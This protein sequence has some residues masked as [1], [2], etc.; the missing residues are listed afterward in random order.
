MNFGLLAQYWPDLWDGFVTTLVLSAI[1]LAVAT[2]V[3]AALALMR[4]SRVPSLTL[5]AAAYVS[6]FR[7]IPA[8]LVLF[9]TFYALP[10]FG[11]RLSPFGAA[12][13]GLSIVGAAYLSEDIRGGLAA[14]DSGQ[15]RAA[16]ALGLSW[17]HT[18]R[19]II[20]PQAIPIIIPP[21]FT[22]AIIIVKSTSLAS[23]VA[24]SDLTGQAARAASITYDPFPFLLTA[25]VLYL[26]LSGAL[27]LF[28][29]WA[30]R[31]VSFSRRV[32]LRTQELG[33]A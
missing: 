29:S 26:A 10:Q 23:F 8:L 32:L 30:E 21:Y 27:A 14:I 12:C 6:I 22:R 2:P 7:L 19:R 1:V 9:F 24:V 16:K 17:S 33:I 3:G 20:L 11:M 31:R 4:E 5:I 15:Y 25:G 28:Q 13:L 18:I